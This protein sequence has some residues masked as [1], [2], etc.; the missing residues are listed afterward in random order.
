MLGKIKS[1]TWKSQGINII[2]PIQ[3]PDNVI[4]CFVDG[5]SVK[6]IWILK[7]M[8]ILFII[9]CLCTFT[10]SSFSLHHVHPLHYKNCQVIRWFMKGIRPFSTIN[11]KVLNMSNTKDL[12][13]HNL[14]PKNNYNYTGS[15]P[16][17]T[18]TAII[19]QK[20]TNSVTH[21]WRYTS[22]LLYYMFRSC[23]TI[24]MKFMFI[25]DFYVKLIW[26]K[27]VTTISTTIKIPKPLILIMWYYCIT[28]T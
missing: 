27:P 12:T 20:K 9:N 8:R 25:H 21:I 19:I 5:I 26:F 22:A 1:I 15:W 2:Q 16:V 4:H 6:L 13:S 28:V 17:C 3:I 7:Q 18:T 10:D 14:Y 23:S 24:V 11:T